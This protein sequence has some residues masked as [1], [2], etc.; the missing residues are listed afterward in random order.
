MPFVLP[1]VQASGPDRPFPVIEPEIEAIDK[2]LALKTEPGNFEEK[3]C[4][5]R[6]MAQ[7]SLGRE[8]DFYPKTS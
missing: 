2:S 3:D 7:P 1:P 5:R 4:I 8:G 6:F